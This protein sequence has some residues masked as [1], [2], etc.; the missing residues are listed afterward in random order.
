M[1][2]SKAILAKFVS[3][4]LAVSQYNVAAHEDRLI[5]VDDWR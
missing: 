1:D 4:M 2:E 3:D 5:C